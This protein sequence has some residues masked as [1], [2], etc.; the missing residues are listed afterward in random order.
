MPQSK[1]HDIEQ[2]PQA[3]KAIAVRLVLPGDA[4]GDLDESLEEIRQLAWTA[5]VETVGAV[6]Q[7]RQKPCP[8]TLIGRGKAEELRAMA[9][10]TGADLILVDSELT[11]AQNTKLEE[12]TGAKVLDRT[13]LILNIFAQRART[14]EGKL[15]VELAQLQYL[16]PRLTGHGVEMSRLGGNVGMR[17]G[18]GEQKLELDRRAIRRRIDSLRAGLERV[19]KTRRVQRKQRTEST[20]ATAAL[21]GYTNA[22]KSSLLRAV[23]KTDAFVEDKLFATLDPCSRRCPLPSQRDI[24]LTDTVGFI[25]KLPHQLVAA[26]RATLEEVLEANLLLIVADGAHPSVERHIE[27]V[28]DVLEE[29]GAADNPSLTVFNKA[30]IAEPARISQLL[31]THPGALAVSAH[32]GHGLD[33]LLDAI[34]SAIQPGW[35][36]VT[37]RIPQHAAGTVSRVYEAGRV[38]QETYEDNTIVLDAEIDDALAGQLREYIM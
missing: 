23:A 17:G 24:V 7:R 25:R 3:E 1:T 10:E 19:R 38:L 14:N 34:D 37:L 16:L 31:N 9:E 18:P 30:D 5:G 4:P 28:Y 13:Q 6:E 2:P 29:I 8:A 32:T 27:A 11:P 22:G 35:T 20:V 26:F 15:Q 12:H 21:V 33:T 36:R